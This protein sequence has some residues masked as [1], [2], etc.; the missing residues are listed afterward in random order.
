MGN[1]KGILAFK[2]SVWQK[3]QWVHTSS[4]FFLVIKP[5]LK[6]PGKV[7]CAIP[8]KIQ[9]ENVLADRLETEVLMLFKRILYKKSPPQKY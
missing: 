6:F 4:V 1:I 9:S 2:I 3:R 8:F 7:N 5:G